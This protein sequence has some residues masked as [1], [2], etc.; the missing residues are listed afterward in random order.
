MKELR[1]LTPG[2]KTEELK[3]FYDLNYRLVE[4]NTA[5][6]EGVLGHPA[7]SKVIST[8]RIVLLSDAVRPPLPP[9]RSFQKG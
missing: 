7:A 1:K 6:I 3:D 9:P 5:V 2:P 8:G 4:L